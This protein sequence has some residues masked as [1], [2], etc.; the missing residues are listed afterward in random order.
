MEDSMICWLVNTSP[1]D[2]KVDQIMDMPIS[3]KGSITIFKM[4]CVNRDFRFY[5]MFLRKLPI[6]F[7][8]C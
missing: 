7:S 1:V 6:A 4:T 5:V 2:K 3:K 8:N